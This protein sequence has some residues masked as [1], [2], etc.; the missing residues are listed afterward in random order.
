MTSYAVM[1]Y[2]GHHVYVISMP[3]EAREAISTLDGK[4]SGPHV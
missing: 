2:Y 1:P 4:A 3:V